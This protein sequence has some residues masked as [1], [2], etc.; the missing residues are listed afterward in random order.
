MDILKSL[1]KNLILLVTLIPTL[2]FS[3]ESDS[4]IWNFNDVDIQTLIKNTSEIT[5]KN[6]VVDPRV[7]GKIT[8]IS[9][10]PIAKDQIYP[11]FVSILNVHGF[12]AVSAGQVVK[13]LPIER[14]IENSNMTSTAANLD[15]LVVKVFKLKFVQASNILV[16]LKPLLSE[17]STI[18]AG[19]SPNYLII[20]DK[21]GNVERLEKIIDQLDVLKEN[22]VDIL[23]VKYSSAS[24]LSNTLTTLLSKSKDKISSTTFAADARTNAILVSGGT[25]ETRN[26]LKQI[27]R[28]LDLPTDNNSNSEVIYLK[29]IE[30]SKIAPIIGT[31]LAD[32][33]QSSDKESER[34][35]THQDTPF[36]NSNQSQGS[37]QKS[38]FSSKHLS[39]LRDY[40]SNQGNQG[41]LFNDNEN[42]EKSGAI[43]QYV[44]WEGSSNALILKAPPN[45][46]QAV[47]SIINKLDIS[48][49]QILIE[50]I[51]AEIGMNR[52]K[53]ISTEWNP[54]PDGDVKFGTRFPTGT[55]AANNI[56]GGFSPGTVE[57]LGSG[58]SLGVFQSGNLKA[59]IKMLQS[60]ASANILSTPTLVTLDNQA[61]LIKVGE[62]VPFAIGTTNNDNVGGNP[63]TSF[64]REEVGLSLTIKPQI[65]HAGGIKLQIENI[66]SNIVPNTATTNSGNNPTTSERTIITNVMVNDGK[67]LVLGGLIQDSWQKT[68]SKVPFLGD[69]PLVGFFFRTHKNELVKKNL[70]IFLRPTIMK[71]ESDLSASKYN[72]IRTDFI[73]SH[74]A[75]DR[76]FI[77][78]PVNLMPLQEKKKSNTALSSNNQDIGHVLLPAPF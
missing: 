7:Q 62:K 15:N 10:N 77:E 12:S 3:L 8:V 52:S 25:P 43:N 69:L 9:Q 2:C 61:A 76:K 46:M 34:R 14:A 70:I 20:A 73:E 17:T 21:E 78:E 55:S 1:I 65:T 6:F 31:F 22:E 49:P 32:A 18:V 4:I 44:Q 39:S 56:V 26:Y 72:K 51:I 64:D 36:N 27:I 59:L 23:H 74:H 33:M 63:F 11:V 19:V 37:N 30:A 13:I 45:L 24:D 48:R 47:R 57:T 67:I 29:Y 66:L 40:E 5:G 38:L 28:Q 58:L 75:F 60:D 53:E 71:E 16:S 50:V 42:A 35:T 54:T 41:S 68:L